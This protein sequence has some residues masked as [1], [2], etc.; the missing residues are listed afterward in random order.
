MPFVP[1]ISSQF[2]APPE[3][4]ADGLEIDLSTGCGEPSTF[5]LLTR[6][7]STAPLHPYS[8][9]SVASFM[10]LSGRFFGYWQRIFQPYL[11]LLAGI[12]WPYL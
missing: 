9:V 12:F 2:S 8:K 3:F 11:F 1:E 4:S 6:Y 7:A 10:R 5:R